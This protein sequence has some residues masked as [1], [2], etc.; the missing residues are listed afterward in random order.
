MTFKPIYSLLLT[1]SYANCAS[2]INFNTGDASE[3]A[4]TVK[5]YTHMGSPPVA[6]Y[7]QTLRYIAPKG[8]KISKKRQKENREATLHNLSKV[9]ELFKKVYSPIIESTFKD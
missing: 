8:P 7:R 9:S 2:I 1:L 3:L 6:I 4:S 5:V